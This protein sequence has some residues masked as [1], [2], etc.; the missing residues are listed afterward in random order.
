[1]KAGSFTGYHDQS[2]SV[3]GALAIPDGK[4]DFIKQKYAKIRTL[5][6]VENGEVKGRLLN[7]KQVSDVVT[8]LARNEVL[9]ELTALYL[10][11]HK[12]SDI[13]AYKQKHTEG[14]LAR[15]GLFR[16]PDRQQIDWACHQISATSLP[17]YLQAITTFEVLHSII[18]RVPLYF[19]QRQPHEL[20]SFRWII[21]GKEPNKVTN[22]EMWW[23]WY[24]RG[25]LANMSR[26]RPAPLLEG[27]DYSFYDKFRRKIDG[28]TELATDVAL[29]MADLRFS[30]AVEPGLEL[31][32]IVVNATRRALVGSLGEAGWCGIPRLMIHRREPYIQFISL[33]QDGNDM[34]RNPSYARTIRR[35]F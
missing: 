28:E 12:E 13:I 11:F 19:A 14:M 20:A 3:V 17:L 23:S 31:A 8:M 30:A 35:F 32:D 18:N 9:F 4:L 1:M 24:A 33:R 27:A 22:W 6:P 5:L 7:E 2:L 10:G 15:V 26:R 29:L 21:D 34:I 25:A 16:E